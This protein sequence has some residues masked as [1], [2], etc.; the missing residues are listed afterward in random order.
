M[1][2]MRSLSDMPNSAANPLPSDSINLTQTIEINHIFIAESALQLAKRIFSL[3]SGK[4]SL[5]LFGAQT[6]GHRPEVLVEMG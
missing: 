5:D 2:N 3:L 1:T 6:D 4:T